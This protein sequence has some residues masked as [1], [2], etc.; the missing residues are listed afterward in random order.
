M[1]SGALRTPLLSTATGDLPKRGAELGTPQTIEDAVISWREGTIE[2]VGAASGYEGSE[3]EQV[4]GAIVPGFVDCHTH[5]PFFGWRADEYAERLAGR[6]YR[7]LH[8]EGGIFRSARLLADAADDEVIDFCVALAREAMWHGTTAMELKTG[9]GLSVEAEL[10]QARLARRLSDRVPQTCTVT[11]LACHAIPR[12]VDRSDWV[13]T[14]CEHLVPAAADEGLVDAV[15]IYVEDIAF[16]V[17][18][19]RALARAASEAGL[20]LRCHVEQLSN[21]G[22]AR[23][24]ADLGAI[25]VDHLNHLDD[26]AVAHLG[27]SR[28]V[29]VLLPASTFILGSASPPA[30]ALI[31]TGAPV[32]IASDFNPG[33][34]PVISMPE[35]IAFA[36][37]LYGLSAIEALVAATANAACVLGL[38]R[39]LGTLEAGKRADLLVLDGPLDAIPYRPGHNPVAA[40]FIGGVSQTR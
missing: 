27:E 19:L 35:V 16:S 39:S 31:D 28:S 37:R 12:D 7:D 5:L 30:R 14:A 26:D 24:A 15:D 1:T 34:S 18:D 8:G 38:D 17:A 3:P 6:S 32:A 2:Y 23:A 29:C 40:T 25:S 11:L 33:T 10:R 21:L 13:R 4:D 22:G 20:P 9:Y 36:A